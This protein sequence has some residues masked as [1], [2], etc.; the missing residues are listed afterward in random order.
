MSTGEWRTTGNKERSVENLEH[1]VILGELTTGM[2]NEK[3]QLGNVAFL[4]TDWQKFQRIFQKEEET[5]SFELWKKYEVAD[6]SL[7]AG[8]DQRQ[9]QQGFYKLEN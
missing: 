4:T 9:C 8:K 5:S 2:E 7:L 3:R 1:Q 6:L